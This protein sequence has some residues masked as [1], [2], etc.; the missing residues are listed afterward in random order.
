MMELTLPKQVCKELD[1]GLSYDVEQKNIPVEQKNIQVEQK[2]IP[3]QP[4]IR[5]K[6]LDWI[7]GQTNKKFLEF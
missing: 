7:A 2:N 5:N 1:Y 3:V 6:E 4:W